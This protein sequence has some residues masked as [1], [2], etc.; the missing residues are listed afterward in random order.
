MHPANKIA[1]QKRQALSAEVRVTLH[2][3]GRYDGKASLWKL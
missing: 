3:T 2:E 1:A